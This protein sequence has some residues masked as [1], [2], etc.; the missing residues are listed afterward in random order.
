MENGEVG[1]RKM[2]CPYG[3]FRHHHVRMWQIPINAPHV[4]PV[5]AFHSLAQGNNLG[6]ARTNNIHTRR[7]DV[8]IVSTINGREIERPILNSKLTTSN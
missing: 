2:C 1:G 3:A 7:D 4:H 8:H 6:H 5:R